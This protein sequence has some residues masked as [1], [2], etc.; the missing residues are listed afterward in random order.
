MTALPPTAL[1]V[2]SPRDSATPAAPRGR[3]RTAG[4]RRGLLLLAVV[5]TAIAGPLGRPSPDHVPSGEVF[6]PLTVT[7]SVVVTP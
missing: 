7:S 3:G 4:L 1:S 2:V 5:L 6:R